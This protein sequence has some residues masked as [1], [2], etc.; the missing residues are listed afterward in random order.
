MN[1][2]QQLIKNSKQKEL[3]A[4]RKQETLIDEQKKEKGK[5]Q[6]LSTLVKL[7]SLLEKVDETYYDYIATLIEKKE[8]IKQQIKIEIERLQNEIFNTFQ[9]MEED[10]YTYILPLPPLDH[11]QLPAPITIHDLNNVSTT[12]IISQPTNISSNISRDD[13]INTSTNDQIVESNSTN[14]ARRRSLRNIHCSCGNRM[15]FNELKHL[16]KNEIACNGHNCNQIITDEN[17]TFYE[18]DNIIHDEQYSDGYR[19]CKK[20]AHLI[21]TQNAAKEQKQNL[22]KKTQ[23]QKT[24]GKKRKKTIINDNDRLY[25]CQCCHKSFK[26][27]GILKQHVKIHA[28]E[29]PYQCEK[30]L[31]QFHQPSSLDAHKK[32]C[33]PVLGF[34]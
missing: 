25:Q 11:S 15:R 22:R 14:S 1:E 4:K 29:K 24:I 8:Q 3:T 13:I 19:L 20:C 7:H 33:I 23:K 12:I 9:Q 10:T 31:K 6:I 16:L 2:L 27:N 34:P 17:V 26:T 28:G 21:L 5:Q 32:R 18:C 30:C